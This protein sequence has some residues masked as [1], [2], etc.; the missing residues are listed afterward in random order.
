[1]VSPESESSFHPTPRAPAADQ[2][3]AGSAARRA[4]YANP[5]AA[6]TIDRGRLRR[7]TDVR[8]ER[9]RV[10][11]VFL[12][13]DPGEFATPP[14]RATAIGS[15]LNEAAQRIERCEGLDHDEH[16]WLRADLERVRERLTDPGVAA[17]GARAVAVY[18]CAPEE[19]LEV[20]TL[21]RSVASRVII[22]RTPAIEPLLAEADGER[23][24][25]ALVNR[26]RARIFRGSGAE[27]SETDRVEDAVFSQHDQGGWSQS[28]YQRGIEKEKDDHLIHVAD[29]LFTIFKEDGF[30]CLLV[31]APDELVGAVEDRLHSGRASGP[32]GARGARPPGRGRRALHAGRRRAGRRARRAQ[33]GQ[34]RHPARRR[35]PARARAARRRHGAAVR[36]RRGR[37]HDLVEPRAADDRTGDDEDSVDPER[38]RRCEPRQRDRLLHASVREPRFGGSRELR[39]RRLRRRLNAY[40][41][42]M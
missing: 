32:P 30:D 38:R 1:M 34:G 40:L 22:E 10:L 14:A 7:L 16:E 11:S 35:G 24:V 8:P 33:R 12:D 5:M 29:L 28:R 2:R 4:G 39:Q 41:F 26:R 36:R 3:S 19:L 31:G 23:W 20:V 21:R 25:V 27:V 6:N 9:G 17:N 37:Q 18:A 42:R 13:L 15:V